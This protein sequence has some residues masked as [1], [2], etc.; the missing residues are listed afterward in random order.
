MSAEESQAILG[1]DDAFAILG[2]VKTN[3]WAVVVKAFRAMVFKVHPDYGGSQKDF[4]QV[5]AA[6][7]RLADE[8]KNKVP[9]SEGSY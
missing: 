1:D 7:S 3:D 6:Y 2:I 9:L 4:E 5:K 8:I